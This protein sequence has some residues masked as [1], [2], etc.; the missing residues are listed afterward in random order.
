M[1]KANDLFYKSSNVDGMC[2]IPEILVVLQQKKIHPVKLVKYLSIISRKH[3]VC[4]RH[5]RKSVCIKIEETVITLPLNNMT[6][7]YDAKRF[8]AGRC[9]EEFKHNKGNFFSTKCWGRSPFQFPSVVLIQTWRQNL[10]LNYMVV[11]RQSDE[12]GHQSGLT[13]PL[14]WFKSISTWLQGF[15][16]YENQLTPACDV[17][18]S[19]N[20]EL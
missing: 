1:L 6:V 2:L 8:P 9:R 13:P 11:R 10:P 16:P 14:R 20:R 12:G 4:V 5:A 15:L 3:Y 17:W 18:I 19:V 7:I